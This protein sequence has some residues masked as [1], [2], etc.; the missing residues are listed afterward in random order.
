MKRF[1]T[2]DE[3][4]TAIR[5]LERKSKKQEKRMTKSFHRIIDNPFGEIGS[6]AKYLFRIITLKRVFRRRK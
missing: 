3:L 6:F 5:R 1:E 2:I 4:N